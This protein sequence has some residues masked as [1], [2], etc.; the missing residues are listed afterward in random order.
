[1]IITANEMIEIPHFIEDPDVTH[2]K[3][4]FKMKKSHQDSNRRKEIMARPV[5]F[6][7]S[8][9]TFSN[10]TKHHNILFILKDWEVMAGA[11]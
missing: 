1:M 9:I 11:L 7:L 10:W 4:H 2:R 3:K 5:G 8:H 6:E